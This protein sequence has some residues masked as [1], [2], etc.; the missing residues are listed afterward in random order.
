METQN[1]KVKEIKLNVNYI[2]FIKKLVDSKIEVTQKNK[3]SIEGLYREVV[4][5]RFTNLPRV[6]NRSL[7]KKLNPV[8]TEKLKSIKLDKKIFEETSQ[9]VIEITKSKSGSS[10]LNASS[11]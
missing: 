1:K 2:T 7:R 11:K 10:L 8:L 6:A 4:N 9:K 3:N 5:L